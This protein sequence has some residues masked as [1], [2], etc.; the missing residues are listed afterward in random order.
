MNGI[1]KVT[2]AL[3][4]SALSL[5]AFAQGQETIYNSVNSYLESLV[6]KPVGEIIE[7]IDA[8]IDAVEDPDKKSDVA[9]IAFDF[10]QESP[11][12][13]QDAVAV[14]I[15][16][17]Y[18]LSKE[19][20]WKDEAT[21]PLLYTYAEFNRSSLIGCDAP[22]LVL[23]NSF[24]IKESVRNL[25]GEYKLLYFYDDQCASCRKETPLL[26]EF[27][28]GYDGEPL[29]VTAI[30]TQSDR[31][32]WNSYVEEHFSGIENKSVYLVHMWDPEAESGYHKKYGVLST[33]QMV[34]LDSQNRIIGRGLNCKALGELL[35][36]ENYYSDDSRNMLEAFF[37]AI[38][39]S[40]VEKAITGLAEA[41]DNRYA[42]DTS[43]FTD[44]F[45]S[46]FNALRESDDYNIQQTAPI[47]AEK[48][49]LGKPEYWSKEYVSRIGHYLESSRMNPVGGRIT[50]IVLW[51]ERGFKKSLVTASRCS[52]GDY[53]VILFHLVSC[54]D[55]REAIEKLLKKAAEYDKAG[56]KV[57]LVYVGDEKASWKEFVSTT[58]RMGGSRWN[59]LWDRKGNSGMH[60]KYDLEYVPSLYIID[61]T[62][63]IVAKDSY[64]SLDGI[65]EPS[66]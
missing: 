49:I 60:T 4:L 47:I 12:M 17:T 33:P 55:C 1:R 2:S 31:D 61:S 39:G 50:D 65:L 57:T 46:L 24:G 8:L 52:D 59:Y 23:E 20:K 13:G 21:Y 43:V 56:I 45:H 18:F 42:S 28:K 35:G 64:S 62:G 11:V 22:E 27:L 15:A 25:E 48:Y 29:T 34:L 3:L 19:L 37:E 6:F 10:F 7:S 63:M 9:G 30:Y 58:K 16:D 41:Y 36:M 51:N 53:S 44:S 5:C 32:R 54:S 14:H 40:D 38:E 66:L 26:A